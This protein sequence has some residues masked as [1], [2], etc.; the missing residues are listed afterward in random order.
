M[1]DI[2]VLTF[3][4]FLRTTLQLPIKLVNGDFSKKP[5]VTDRFN[6]FMH[7]CVQLISHLNWKC[8][9]LWPSP[10]SREEF[11]FRGKNWSYC[12]G[13]TVDFC[14]LFFFFFK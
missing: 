3:E 7:A 10:S 2:S 5:I 12:F 9:N 1:K 14:R 13:A 4:L 11:L 8:S 6:D